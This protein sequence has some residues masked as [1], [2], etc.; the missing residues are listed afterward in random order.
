M[1]TFLTKVL[2][3]TDEA[4]MKQSLPSIPKIKQIQS[5]WKGIID[6]MKSLKE[7]WTLLEDKK[8]SIFFKVSVAITELGGPPLV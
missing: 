6:I 8:N 4:R 3:V 5:G 1:S 7:S 2:S